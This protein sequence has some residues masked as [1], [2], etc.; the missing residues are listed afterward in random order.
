MFV[1][2]RNPTLPFFRGHE[3]HDPARTLAEPSRSLLNWQII[4]EKLPWNV[5]ILMGVLNWKYRQ[6]NYYLR[7]VLIL[8]CSIF[9]F[10]KGGAVGMAEVCK[11]SGLTTRIGAQ[12]ANI[13]FLSPGLLLLLMTTLT[14]FLTEIASNAATASVVLPIMNSMVTFLLLM[15]LKSRIINSCSFPKNELTVLIID[16]YY[17][18]YLLILPIKGNCRL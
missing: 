8:D 14:A 10:F 15:A 11:T 9:D 13:D 17:Y 5:V 1:I 2:P 16:Y 3:S 18:Y 12:F 4:H 7:S 6:T